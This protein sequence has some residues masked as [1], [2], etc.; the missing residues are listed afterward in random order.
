MPLVSDII[1]SLI[2]GVSQQP[3][4]ARV[5]GKA[6]IA[7]NALFSLFDG[8][9][10]RPPLEYVENLFNGDAE[11]VDRP[12]IRFINRDESTR[13]AVWI[14]DQVI[15]VF[16][17]SDGSEKTVVM[18]A[19]TEDYL[20]TDNARQDL[21]LITV[22][23]TAFVWNRTITA[24]NGS[25]VSDPQKY[26]AIVYVRSGDYGRRYS[27]VVDNVE[28]YERTAVGSAAGH[29]IQVSAENIARVLV[30]GDSELA[31][32]IAESGG[33]G[34]GAE[35]SSSGLSALGGSFTVTRRGSLIYISN[36]SDFTISVDD[37]Q[38][39]T[40]MTLVK[41]TVAKI[42]DLPSKAFKDFLVKVGKEGGTSESDYYLTFEDD[43]DDGTGVWRE[44]VGPNENLGVDATT[45]PHALKHNADDTFTFSAVDYS[46]RECGTSTITPD[47]TFVGR[48]I[49]AVVYHFD[50]LGFVSG[51]DVH[52]SATRDLYRFYRKTALSKLDDDPFALTASSDGVSI[53][54]HCV[55][56]GGTIVFFSAQR[57][58]QLE[59]TSERFTAL[60]AAL[61]ETKSYE[62][63]PLCRPVNAGSSLFFTADRSDYATFR[64]YKPLSQTTADV[65]DEI[66][67]DIPT[68][69]PAGVHT[70]A[71]SPVE[72]TLV[73]LNE[74][75]PQTLWVY[76]WGDIDNRRL[77]SSWS[78]WTVTDGADITIL[79]ADFI[80]SKLYLIYR[81]DY[82]AGGTRSIALATL[83]IA[84]GVTD[85]ESTYKVRLDWLLHSADLSFVYD[86]DSDT[87]TITLPYIANGLG[88]SVV[89]EAVPGAVQLNVLEPTDTEELDEVSVPG[90]LTGL[91][92]WVGKPYNFHYR[93]SPF[94]VRKGPNQSGA[95][96]R[97]G[98][99]QIADLA[100][101]LVP[102]Y[103]M[104]TTVTNEGRTPWTKAFTAY[105]SEILDD[106]SQSN[107]NKAAFVRFTVAAQN[108]RTLIDLENSTHLP[109]QILSAQWR[110]Q[111]NPRTNPL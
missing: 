14:Q 107:G 106:E 82:V 22:G 35:A 66:G 65:S 3:A 40:A 11:T 103:Y 60:G 20:A 62:S 101:E 87:S 68:Y 61:T 71:A 4:S 100:V 27:V 58:F 99:L 34:D 28:F 16:D 91:R 52:Y 47:P 29:T 104:E 42:G 37:G 10:K 109:C 73:A 90:D 12:L 81:R 13:Y 89:A 36:T 8:T 56:V 83:N 41:G 78:D 102:P 30:G 6:E 21:D 38:G 64:E 105:N 67:V 5:P 26:E 85:T 2:G 92:Y 110:G 84:P 54:R 79:G 31:T 25:D 94:F 93:F 96:M 57:Q 7:T 75:S 111:F 23:D 24:A 44:T 53:L 55:S 46:Q 63:N 51:E 49:N 98:R 43:D 74:A 69:V 9:N 18:D 59:R 1:P 97:D 39:G 76:R 15:R 70:L 17:L 19:D 32:V 86:E 33:N 45:L 88:L 95:V 80:G 72:S 77:M 48:Q 50:R 108:T